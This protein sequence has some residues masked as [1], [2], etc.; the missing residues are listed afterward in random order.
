MPTVHREG[1]YRFHFY[2]GD[3][4]EP[5]HIHV[6]RADAEAKFW[7]VSGALASNAG[8]SRSELREIARLVEKRNDILLEGWYGYF[9]D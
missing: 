3:R 8:F 7:L 4:N 1:P 9:T 2:A 5:P 6:V